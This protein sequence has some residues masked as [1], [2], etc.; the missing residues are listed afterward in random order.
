MPVRPIR[1]R[2]DYD[3]A[4]QRLAELISLDLPL[5][6]AQDDELELLQ[7]VIGR[8]DDENGKSWPLSPIEAIE[9]RMQQGEL[10][11][12]DLEPFIGSLSRVSEVLSGKRS[13]T[14]QMMRKL[15]DGLGIPAKSLI[16]SEKLEAEEDEPEYDFDRFPLKEMQDR[17]LFGQSSLSP[18]SLRAQARNLVIPLLRAGRT[19]PASAALLRA[20][21]HQSGNRTMD[22]YGLL[23]WR[24]MVVDK[25]R[26][27]KTRAPYKAGTVTPAWLRS[28][29]KLS[30]FDEGPRLAQEH[31]S[32]HGICL[33]FAKHFSKTYLDGAAMLDGDMPIVALTLRH[34]RADNFWFALLHELT[35]IGKHLGKTRLF[36]ADN[37]EDKA[38]DSKQEEQEADAAA[39]EALIPNKLW[40]QSPVK[41]THAMED[42]LELARKAEISPAIVAGRIRWHTGNW[43]LLSS[44]IND[45]GPVSRHF[46]DQLP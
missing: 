18:S 19:S 15:H 42:A 22:D 41:E 36:I 21:L 2:E 25:A 5:G 14:V 23:V 40:E 10:S 37:L 34:D 17:G 30:V 45:A 32:R 11:K 8:Y 12:K 27:R 9:F 38:R 4:V 16:G 28:I 35:H 1:S 24:L 20:P 7:M 44:L 3:A 13:L 6:H 39:Q 46:A 33:V 31:L 26:T 29:A 43:R